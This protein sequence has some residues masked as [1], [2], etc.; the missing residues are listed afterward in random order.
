MGKTRKSD[1][2]QEAGGEQQSGPSIE[3]VPQDAATQQNGLRP[4]DGARAKEKKAPKA[5]K[6]L[7]P[8]KQAGD[9]KDGAPA[10]AKAAKAPKAPKAPKAAP[11]PQLLFHESLGKEL[12]QKFS[13]ITSNPVRRPSVASYFATGIIEE[14]VQE[15]VKA[16]VVTTVQ[17]TV[18]VEPIKD[19]EAQAQPSPTLPGDL[20]TPTRT[21]AELIADATPPAKQAVT[22]TSPTHD[23]DI[24][25]KK[26]VPGKMYSLRDMNAFQSIEA[27]V[28]RHGRMT[29]MGVRDHNYDFFL[30]KSKTGVISYRLVDDKVA[31]ISGDP[32]CAVPC[33]GRLLEE[34]GVYC[35]Y[36]KWQW[37][38]QG[39]SKEMAD[40][41]KQHGWTTVQYGKERALNVQTNPVLLG[42]EGKRIRTQC[43]QLQ[44]T[45]NVGIY[46][47]AYTRDH[48]LET[49]IVD[50]YDNWRS[51]RNT[52]RSVQAYVTVFD[53]LSMHR[54]MI[55]VYTH[56]AAGKLLGFAALRR[57]REGY[58]I[59]P[60]TVDPEAPRGM[61]DLLLISSMAL[62]K[63][64]NIAR[65][66]LGVE[67]LDDL[68]EI[69]GMSKALEKLTRKSHRLISAELPLGGKKGF[70]DRFRPD[71]AFEE[72][73]FMIYPNSPSIKQSVAMAHFANIHL[74]EAVKQRVNREREKRRHN[75][76]PDVGAG[77][78]GARTSTDT[79]ATAS[80]TTHGDVRPGSVVRS[81]SDGTA[82]HQDERRTS[83][84]NGM[85][86]P[87]S[88]AT[89]ERSSSR[90]RF[91][92]HSSTEEARK[93]SLAD[94][95][96][97]ENVSPPHRES[98]DNLAVRPPVQH[99]RS[100][101][102]LHLFRHG[103][104]DSSR[105]HHH[106]FRHSSQDA[107]Q[108]TLI[109][110]DQVEP[111]RESTE[112]LAIRPRPEHRRSSSRL[113]IFKY[114]SEEVK[115]VQQHAKMPPIVTAGEGELM[116]MEAG[117][118]LS[119]PMQ[120]GGGKR[121]R[122]RSRIGLFRRKSSEVVPS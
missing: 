88:G 49:Q 103:S 101:S 102:R 57:L 59:D 44:K 13:E 23:K 16:T 32:I 18:V 65:L 66:V 39:A 89:R 48:K 62:L 78:E 112:T 63:E 110:H 15:D 17:K 53:L 107:S 69:T 7:K 85:L 5:P 99:R 6:A 38:I 26:S 71:D 119:P 21:F 73:L 3:H 45:V 109:D 11:A 98:V 46:C 114:N 1:G 19:G 4:E 61:T 92:R 47:P 96:P 105:H 51:S 33:Y 83:E 120:D 41:A 87:A 68:G 77:D 2:E 94:V 122:S 67:P 28:A 58:H 81:S 116:T 14:Q 82:L 113:H 74:H 79:L 52:S 118:L 36:N 117:L 95:A 76:D 108:V 20:A 43:K 10:E 55:W 84:E 24:L 106:L 75:S 60:I 91:F 12:T 80:G 64:S 86:K 54:L 25:E 121:E 29:H 22:T 111:P 37:A 72:Q 35:K 115:Q 31:V 27:L 104:E 34:F 8:P 97:D 93:D 100:S 40:I 56:D 50:M 30:N 9:H 42:S 90:I 70:N